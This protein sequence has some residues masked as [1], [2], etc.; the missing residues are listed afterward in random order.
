MLPELSVTSLRH[1]DRC[2]L[3]KIVKLLISCCSPVSVVTEQNDPAAAA[4]LCVSGVTVQRAMSF[5]SPDF[6]HCNSLF[7][8]S[9][10]ALAAG[11]CEVAAG[12]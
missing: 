1:S 3:G 2:T 8:S 7:S 10:L 11:P 6:V 9:K 5:Q 12:P 4:Y